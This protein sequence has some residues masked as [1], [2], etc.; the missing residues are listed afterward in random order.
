M[1]HRLSSSRRSLLIGAAQLVAAFGLWRPSSAAE[2]LPKMIVTRD[3]NCG[4]CG[5]WVTHV[6]AA[7]FPVEVVEVADVAPLKARLGV[8]DALASCHTVEVG[9]Y[10]VEGHVPAEAIKRLLAERPKATGLAVAGMPVG[11]PGM[12][13]SGQAPDAYDVVVFSA[14]RQNVFARYRGLRQI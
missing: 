9:G 4:C 2:T 13:V 6:K 1:T 14:D 12:E 11:S 10:V 8:P 7:G 5:N 3:P